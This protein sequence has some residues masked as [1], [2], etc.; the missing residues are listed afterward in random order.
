MRHFL[1]DLW[2]GK[3]SI[4]VT[5]VVNFL[6]PAI[7]L[8]LAQKLILSNWI[9]SQLLPKGL[10]IT[11]LLVLYALLVI[12]TAVSLNRSIRTKNASYSTGGDVAVANSVLFIGAAYFFVAVTDL[13]TGRTNDVSVNALVRQAGGQIDNSRSQQPAFTRDNKIATRLLISGLIDSGATRR[14][15]SIL[16]ASQTQI[17]PIKQLFLESSG[18]NIYEARGMARLVRMHGLDTHVETQCLSACTLVFVSGAH[19]TAI[20]AAT[21]GFHSYHLDAEY[22]QVWS[23]AAEEEKK[24]IE[25]FALN[26][27]DQALTAKIYTANHRNLWT[28]PHEELIAT[29]FLHDTVDTTV[30]IPE[31][32]LQ[33]P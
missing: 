30:T 3:L 29:G 25:L 4:T 27:V 12:T 24:D 26:G 7:G 8:H 21:F 10:T 9:D 1:H 23:N 14:L 2:L 33:S 22:P 13:V 19:R 18:G 32:T 15:Q 20:A 11:T 28:P 5:L 31:N 6:V 17:P 16:E